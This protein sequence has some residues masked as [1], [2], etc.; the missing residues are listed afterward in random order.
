MNGIKKA[1][2][3]V[4]SCRTI[5]QYSI[6]VSY[7]KMAKRQAK[8]DDLKALNALQDHAEEEIETLQA[9]AHDNR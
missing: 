8:G 3:V 5:P 9:V 7:L 4:N 2:R 6:A 1:T